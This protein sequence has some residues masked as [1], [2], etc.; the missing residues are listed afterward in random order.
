MRVIKAACH[1]YPTITVTLIPKIG[2]KINSLYIQRYIP[3]GV[4]T[5]LRGEGQRKVSQ[6]RRQEGGRANQPG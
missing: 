6:A 1:R 3:L 2:I 5:L 4:H